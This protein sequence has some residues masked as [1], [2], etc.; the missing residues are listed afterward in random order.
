MEKLLD[1]ALV[2]L[3]SVASD[4]FGAGRAM[5]E[6]LIAGERDPKVLAELARG[7]MQVKKPALL[8]ALTGRFDDHHAELARLLLD[9]VDALS[10]QIDMLTVRIEELIAQILAAAAPRVDQAAGDSAGPLS[11]VERLDENSY[12]KAVRAGEIDSTPAP[13][14]GG[15]GAVTTTGGSIGDGN[16][17]FGN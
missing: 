7:R 12:L 6:A 8:Q 1:D 10:A 2:K 14:S 4:I 13:G 11:A 17:G 16:I 15:A 9:Q 5:I 3:S